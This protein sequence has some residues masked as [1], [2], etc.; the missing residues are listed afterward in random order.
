MEQKQKTKTPEVKDTKQEK[1]PMEKVRIDKIVLN[2]GGTAE[3]LEKGVKLLRSLT[4]RNPAKMK[5][6][7]R[8]PSLG[9]RPNLEVGALVTIRKNKEDLLR[10]MLSVSDNTLR[11]NQ[12]SENSFSFG[13]KEH[14]EIPGVE[15]EREI[16]IRGLDI[17]VTFKRAGKRVKLKKAK[18]GK[19]P[20][21]HNISK[22]EIIKFMEEE[23]KT[24]FV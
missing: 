14:I 3:E 2:V 19:L 23:F 16:G 8:I 9:V 7:R 15:Y 5:S 24:K 21:R 12:I 13:I 17:T 18:R 6:R 1:N 4:G 11:K 22:E 20:K 10:K